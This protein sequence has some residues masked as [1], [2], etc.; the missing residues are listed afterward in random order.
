VSV[1]FDALRHILDS[2]SVNEH[3]V[4]LI[5]LRGVSKTYP[6]A[7]GGFTALDQ[8]NLSLPAGELTAVVGKSGSGKSTLANLIAGID[9]PSRGEV[10]VGGTPVHALDE[11]RLAAWRGRNVGVVFQSFQLLP[12]LTV[13]E[14]ILLPMDFCAT[15]TPVEARARAGQLLERVGIADQSDKLPAALSGGQQQRAAIARAL[16][17]DPPLLVA[18]EPTGNL[19]S[20]T[21]EAVLSLL[22]EL[23]RAGKTVVVVSHERDLTRIADRV[24]TLADGR[25]VQA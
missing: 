8:L 20:R 21:A 5:E 19:D 10:V 16:A 24:V 7:G 18:D 17:N 3:R 6:T 1:E 23:T 4:Q 15:C 14:N 2:M 12:T 22:T 13:L 25:M 11:S 9:R